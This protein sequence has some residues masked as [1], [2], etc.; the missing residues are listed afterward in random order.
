MYDI[1]KELR[2]SKIKNSMATGIA[3]KSCIAYYFHCGLLGKM[4][5]RKIKN[6]YKEETQKALKG[7]LNT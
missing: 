3:Q 6:I 7:I 5:C 4:I 2:K 1:V